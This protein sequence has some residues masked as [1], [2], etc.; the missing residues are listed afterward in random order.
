MLNIRN[1]VIQ[2]PLKTLEPQPCLIPE[3]V[4][5]YGRPIV[6]GDGDGSN[7]PF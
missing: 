5:S 2:Q 1:S 6:L 7:N 4:K 3:S